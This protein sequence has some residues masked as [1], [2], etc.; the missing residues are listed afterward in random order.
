MHAEPPAPEP[1]FQLA[2]L[3]QATNF[4]ATGG[5]CA[6]AKEAL[7]VEAQRASAALL[8]AQQAEAEAA[9]AGLELARE[10]AIQADAEAAKLKDGSRQDRPGSGASPKVRSLL[11]RLKNKRIS[12]AEALLLLPKLLKRK[13]LR[14][15]QEVTLAITLLSKRSLFE[16]AALLGLDA[17]DWKNEGPSKKVPGNFIVCSAALGAARQ[18]GNWQLALQLLQHAETASIELDAGARDEAFRALLAPSRIGSGRGGPSALQAAERLQPGGCVPA[19]P[20]RRNSGSSSSGRCHWLS[21]R[22]IWMPPPGRCCWA[23]CRANGRW[24]WRC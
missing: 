22:A 24:R 2:E 15:P 4:D 18:A 20:R 5:E 12:N 1:D 8:R 23:R 21:C 6:A 9:E 7:N 13:V 3:Q 17:C 19:R 10:A 14:E 16:E 11:Q